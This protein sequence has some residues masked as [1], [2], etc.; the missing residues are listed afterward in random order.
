MDVVEQQQDLLMA[1]DDFSY[2]CDGKGPGFF[3]PS[4]TNVAD[5]GKKQPSAGRVCY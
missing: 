2:F 1:L 3:C 5:D 4:F